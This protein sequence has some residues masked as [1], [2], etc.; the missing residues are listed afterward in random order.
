MEQPNW[1]EN[2]LSLRNENFYHVLKKKVFY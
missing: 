1:S 2:M